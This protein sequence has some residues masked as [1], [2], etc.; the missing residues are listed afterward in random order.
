MSNYILSFT[1]DVGF[2]NSYD[3]ELPFSADND[4][5]ATYRAVST[6]FSSK[7]GLPGHLAWDFTVTDASGKFVSRGHWR[8]WNPLYVNNVEVDKSN[9]TK[10]LPKQ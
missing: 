8:N 3:R 7:S 6:M 1:L 5:H 10:I 4:N 9:W 2:G